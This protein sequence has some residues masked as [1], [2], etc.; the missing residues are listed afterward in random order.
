MTESN[1]DIYRAMLE[2]LSDGVMAVDF[3]GTVQIANSALYQMF[4]LNPD[5]VIGQSFGELFLE[6]EGIE[7]FTQIIL[8]TVADRRGCERSVA[9]VS[10]GDE[11]RTLSVTTS[12]LTEMRGDHE[13]RIAL[14]AVVAD[15]TEIKELRETE[16]RMA[17]VVKEQLGE[18]QTA[19]R[20]IEARN[21]TLSVT[22]KRLQ[23]ARGLAVL[24]VLGLFVGIGSWY[25][26]PLDIFGAVFA[27]Q[28]SFEIEPENPAPAF[29]MVV[30]PSEFSSTISLRG[31]LAPGKVERV[32]SPLDSNIRAVYVEPWQD[33]VEGQA[34]ADFTI[35]QLEFDLRQAQVDL[36]R[37]QGE[38]AELE[39]WE[40]SEEITRAR[41]ALR[42]ARQSLENAQ[43][44]FEQNEFLFGEGLIAASVYEKA[45]QSLENQRVDY[46]ASERELDSVA[47]KA[48]EEALSVARLKVDRAQSQV[49]EKQ[50]QID[51]ATV[52]APIKGTLLPAEGR[53]AKPF[54]AGRAV[55]Q[56]ELLA[57]IADF[58]QLS[59][60]VAVDEI[61]VRN[62]EIG[63]QAW[64]TGP[65]FPGIRIE[66]QVT[67]ISS[68]AGGGAIGRGTP[69]FETVVT[70]DR[71]SPDIRDE[72]RV[73]MSTHVTV[74]VHHQPDAIM[75]PLGAVVQ[76]GGQS[77]VN[78]VDPDNGATTQ[79][80]VEVG[81]T[82]L[83]EVEIVDG[84][85]AGDT[86]AFP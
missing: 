79:R 53:N 4:G 15:I 24:A 28:E 81:L 11:A 84:L 2:N 78:V 7:E 31:N 50:D 40:N 56:G 51:R 63:Q 14:I 66:G 69:S 46:A 47:N 48:D 52:K 61:D 5:D 16:L 60:K 74:V 12:Y 3:G 27:P 76:M 64:I 22:M 38:L 21:D 36:V 9:R 67:S 13:E 57:S 70:L 85:S 72:L 17:A 58:E 77:F 65:A 26:R 19:Y 86:I 44:D 37:A 1:F 43:R 45:Q 83:S 30:E 68:R 33:V 59:V 20:D 18:L 55:T 32:V 54:E 82:S 6:F 25:F 29:T 35:G 10:S 42:R 34:L 41:S 71:L 73:G 62:V 75:I 80:V 49:Q 23:A 8:D 39:D